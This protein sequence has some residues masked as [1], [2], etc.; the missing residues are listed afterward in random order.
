MAV[1]KN[2]QLNVC[3][4]PQVINMEWFVLCL[5]KLQKW[6]TKRND[7]HLS[8]DGFPLTVPRCSMTVK[9]ENKCKIFCSKLL[10]V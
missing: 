2:S 3:T 10:T 1:K 7:T 4:N 5:E 9:R 8:L 6:K